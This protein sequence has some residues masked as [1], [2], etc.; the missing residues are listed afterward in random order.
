MM[1]TKHS[2]G[3]YSSPSESMTVKLEIPDFTNQMTG[4][5]DAM[6]KS[7][8]FTIR[9]IKFLIGL[10]PNDRNKK[11][12]GVHLFNYSEDTITAK[13]TVKHDK[14]GPAIVFIKREIEADQ[15]YGHPKLYSHRGFMKSNDD[16]VFRLELEVT[17][18]FS[19]K[20]INSSKKRSGLLL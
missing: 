1:A 16:N 9:G 14:L 13:F 7:P 11:N 8:M 10:S 6:V 20:D 17:L 19:A 4:G 5:A 3:N 18:Y 2:L 12:I 15:G